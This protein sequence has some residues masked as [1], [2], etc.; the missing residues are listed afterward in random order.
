LAL[1]FPCGG[2]PPSSFSRFQLVFCF[3]RICRGNETLSPVLVISTIFPSAPP[4]F[5]ITAQLLDYVRQLSYGLPFTLCT[6]LL[7]FFW[8]Y[9]L[10]RIPPSFLSFS[11]LLGLPPQNPLPHSPSQKRHASPF[12]LCSFIGV[13]F[14]FTSKTFF[15]V[16]VS[17]LVRCTLRAFYRYFPPKT[18][19]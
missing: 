4:V 8:S 17:Y 16:S 14:F 11:L 12:R 3:Q 2:H 6:P 5:S 19:A 7:P 15:K 1:V 10:W 13:S 9:P 18:L